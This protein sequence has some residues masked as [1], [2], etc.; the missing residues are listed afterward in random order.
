MG[1]MKEVWLLMKELDLSF[2]EAVEVIHQ[3]KK[4][5]Y[6]DRKTETELSGRDRK[7]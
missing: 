1:K 5:Q 4:D 3:R 2:P 6:G 7:R